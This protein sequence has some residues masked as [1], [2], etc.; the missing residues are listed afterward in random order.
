MKKTI[1]SIIT[2]MLGFALMGQA[3]QG[4]SHQAVIR[5]AANELVANSPV[6]IRVSI[7]Q[8]APDSTEV[9]AEV[10]TPV[11]NANGL[12]TFVIGQGNDQ[13]SDFSAIDWAGG[14]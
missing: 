4:I 9:Y 5:N 1:L 2:I 14:P 13:S 7:L 10:H 11:S 3:P 6:G 8:G 12:I